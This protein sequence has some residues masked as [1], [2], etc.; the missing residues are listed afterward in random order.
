TDEATTRRA[1][2]QAVH[3]WHDDPHAVATQ[4]LDTTRAV[5]ARLE[6]AARQ[7]PEQ[8][9]APTADRLDPR[10]TGQE[11]WPALAHVMQKL[12]DQ[13]HDVENLARSSVTDEP[14]VSSRPAQALRYRLAVIAPAAPRTAHVQ[15]VSRTT[16]RDEDHHTAPP[17]HD[18]PSGVP[19]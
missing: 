9:W 14:L 7:T 10:L 4:Q 8:R 11:D 15:V 6:A 1:L 16:R 19:R 2:H 13:G 3:A 18:R 17:A 12:H 5:R